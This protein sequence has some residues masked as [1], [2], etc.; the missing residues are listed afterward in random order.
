M[1]DDQRQAFEDWMKA[2]SYD[3]YPY[4]DRFDSEEDQDRPDEY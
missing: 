2:Q 1:V 4:L 3:P